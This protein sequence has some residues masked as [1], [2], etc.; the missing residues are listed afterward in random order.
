[1]GSRSLIERVVLSPRDEAFEI[2]LVGEIARMV[3]VV[4]SSGNKKAA[5][6]ERTACLVKV[7]AGARYASNLGAD[8]HQISSD[9]T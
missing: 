9:L 8:R 1:M 3:E 4:L 2:E 7:V 5:L 6:D